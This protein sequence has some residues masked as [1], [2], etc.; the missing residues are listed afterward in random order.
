MTRELEH[1][2][3]VTADQPAQQPAPAGDACDSR[4]RDRVRRAASQ[5][6]AIQRDTPSAGRGQLLALDLPSQSL[7]AG[8]ENSVSGTRGSADYLCV[9]LH[10]RGVARMVGLQLTTVNP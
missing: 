10:V 7:T 8:A 1:L 2:V 3:L 9:A 5:L 6:R 4:P